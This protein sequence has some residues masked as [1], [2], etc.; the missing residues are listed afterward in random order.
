MMASFT[1]ISSWAVVEFY[2][3]DLRVLRGNPIPP[4]SSIGISH[5][6][7]AINQCGIALLSQAFQNTNVRASL[8]PWVWTFLNLNV[9]RLA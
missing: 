6:R 9:D 2:L 3:R 1:Y 7:V 5:Q 4:I 8:C